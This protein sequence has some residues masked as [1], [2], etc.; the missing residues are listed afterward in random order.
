[1]G[2]VQRPEVFKLA[3]SGAPVVHWELY[4]TAYTERYMGMTGENVEGYRKSSV[5]SHIP[6]FPDR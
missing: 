1:M 2:L 4:D 6:K 5:I 3:V